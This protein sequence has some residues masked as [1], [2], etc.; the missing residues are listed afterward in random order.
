MNSGVQRCFSCNIRI[1]GGTACQTKV[2]V[3]LIL[4][5]VLGQSMG[6]GGFGEI[7]ALKF[8]LEENVRWTF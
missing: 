2:L 7:A 4:D 8:C 5:K 1:F 6:D 3:R